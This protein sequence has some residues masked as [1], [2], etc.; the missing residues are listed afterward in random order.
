[1]PPTFRSEIPDCDNFE[2]QLA[3][4]RRA[5]HAKLL[6]ERLLAKKHDMR[7]VSQMLSKA[8]FELQK[9]EIELLHKVKQRQEH[10]IAEIQRLYS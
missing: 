1:M 10:L 6:I 3:Y 2:L 8:Q 4:Q 9:N 7:S 5:Q